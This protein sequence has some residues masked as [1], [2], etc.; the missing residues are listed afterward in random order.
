M[1]LI[2]QMIK[3]KTQDLYLGTI[4]YYDK[5]EDRFVS[6]ITK[7]VVM[8]DRSCGLKSV[9][10]NKEYVTQVMAKNSKEEFV[11][12]VIID[13]VPY[14][15]LVNGVPKHVSK[16]EIRKLLE[17]LNSHY[18]K[19]KILIFKATHKFWEY[20]ALACFNDNA[21]YLWNGDGV[22]EN[23]KLG[24]LDKNG[25]FVYWNGSVVKKEDLRNLVN[26][27][28]AIMKKYKQDILSPK[29]ISEIREEVISKSWNDEEL[30]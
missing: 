22:Q 11:Y 18:H 10:S 25:D 29:Q 23:M 27:Y 24:E 2:E 4:A 14:I 3:F 9:I 8:F 13:F 7:D 19:D 30:S 16:F 5:S 17:K 20:D 15:V 21:Y 1:R 12:D 28:P 26:A 6:Q